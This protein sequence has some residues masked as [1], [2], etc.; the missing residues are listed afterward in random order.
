M[1]YLKSEAG[2]VTL[3]A[4][5]YKRMAKVVSGISARRR[6]AQLDGLDLAAALSSPDATAAILTSAASDPSVPQSAALTASIASTAQLSA[7]LSTQV[8]VC[9]GGGGGGLS[10]MPGCFN[11]EILAPLPFFDEWRGW[12]MAGDWPVTE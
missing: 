12:W 1:R 2:G 11:G 6:L 7:L 5:V 10:L 4:Y 8:R 9:V 3:A